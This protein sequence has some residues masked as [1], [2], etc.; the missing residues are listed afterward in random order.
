VG[1]HGSAGSTGAAWVQELQAKA[2][3]VSVGRNTYGHP[4]PG[5][6]ARLE[7]GGVSIW[8]T[9]RDGV[10]TVVTDGHAMEVRGK[11]RRTA[12][13]DLRDSNL[14]MQCGAATDC[15]RSLRP[16]RGVLPQ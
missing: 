9:D 10:V 15:P 5:A 11:H 2:A 12:F 16:A 3:L 14:S 4:D 6:L 1:H 7:G 8:R 13:A